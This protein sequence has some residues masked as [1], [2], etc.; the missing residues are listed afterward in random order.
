[1]KTYD[2]RLKQTWSKTK[3]LSLLTLLKSV[4]TPILSP[5]IL[6]Q[7]MVQS[8]RSRLWKMKLLILESK[9]QQTSCQ[10]QRLSLKTLPISVL[11]P[12]SSLPVRIPTRQS[13]SLTSKKLRTTLDNFLTTSTTSKIVFAKTTLMSWQM[14]TVVSG[15]A[16]LLKGYRYGL[17]HIQNMRSISSGQRNEIGLTCLLV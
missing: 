15:W 7:P 13:L 16:P 14:N 11:T 5:R 8:L 2:S 6:W 1:M 4:P 9:L 17:Q 3:K 10:N 12:I